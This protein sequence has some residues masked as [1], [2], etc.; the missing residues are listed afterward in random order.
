MR[1]MLRHLDH[2]DF[3]M[4]RTMDDLARDIH[5]FNYLYYEIGNPA[6]ADDVYDRKKVMLQ[7][8]EFRWPHLARRWSPT[9]TCSFNEEDAILAYGK[10]EWEILKRTYKLLRPFSSM[11]S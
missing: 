6:V 9:C 1:S 11:G 3:G 2:A 7:K 10:D 5:R 4:Q 8:W